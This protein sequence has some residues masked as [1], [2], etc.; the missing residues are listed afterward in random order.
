MIKRITDTEYLSIYLPVNK[1]P[2][3][4]I[5]FVVDVA[6][7]RLSKLESSFSVDDKR[8]HLEVI[9]DCMTIVNQFYGVT[10]NRKSLRESMQN[11]KLEEIQKG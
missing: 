3:P 9:A 11:I 7:Q 4:D 8:S 2:Q 5:A 10:K 6:K 1:K